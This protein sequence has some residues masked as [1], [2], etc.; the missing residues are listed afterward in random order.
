[1]WT[2]LVDEFVD[3]WKLGA[4][5]FK[6]NWQTGINELQNSGNGG[7]LFASYSMGVANTISD[8]ASST[9]NV[10]R[11]PGEAISNVAKEYV[12]Y[13]KKDFKNWI[14]AFYLGTKIG[15]GLINKAKS[16]YN[17]GAEYGLN[18]IAYSLGESTTLVA[19]AGLSA[20]SGKMRATRH[21]VPGRDDMMYVTRYGR[22]GLEAGDW[23]MPGKNTWSNYIRSGKWDPFTWNKFAPKSS[24]QTFIVPKNTVKWPV[25]KGVDA[26][27]KGIFGQRQYLP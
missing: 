15:D 4:S 11:N 20:Y 8:Q 22:S 7:Q 6:D 10:I 17:L 21:C 18:G 26:S 2:L 23:I 25:G 16:S 14:P 5:E 12:S 1:M 27:W 3:N 13:G 24:G 9:I 19:E